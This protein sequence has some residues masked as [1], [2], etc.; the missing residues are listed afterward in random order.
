[1]NIKVGFVSLGC[2]KNLMN[3]ERMLALLA[4]EG[5]EIVAEDV[6]ADVM[7]INTCAFIESAKT[8]AIDSILDIAWLKEHHTLKG[9]VVAGCLP[10]R[11]GDEIL[12]EL[13][14]V[15]CIIG[16]GSVEKICEAVRA[17]YHGTSY[18]A[19]DDIH[20]APFGGERVVTTPEHF[21]YLQISE[22]C[23]NCCTYCVIP[24]IRGK[25]RSRPMSDLVEE[26]TELAEL[27]IKELCLIAQDTTRY[28]EDLYGTYA[29]DSLIA[30][31]SQIE[32]IEWIRLLYCYPDRITDGL[33]EEIANNPK[34]VKYIDMPIQ[35]INDDILK[36][37]NRRSNKAQ[38]MEVI[39]K[40]RSRVPG[41]ILRSTV[42]V[43]F[44]GETAAQFE[45]LRNFL[46]EI[47]FERLGVF[48][49]SR[50]E[51]TPAYDFP[52]QVSEKTKEK[53]NDILM[54]QQERIH[55]ECNE[56]F[57]GQTLKVICE[58]Y[59]QVSESFFGRSYADAYDI[60]GKIFF[61]ASKNVREGQFVNVLITEVM[62]YDLVGKV[63]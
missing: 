21:A 38:I 54:E 41:I 35:H 15:N 6:E 62:D 31:L 36:R 11:Y 2:P 39:Q 9:I 49:Y 33:I 55:N 44:P 57:L 17:A 14:E 19:F 23:D 40:L 12:K 46:K 50:E 63:V 27:G 3:T 20:T 22:G 18:R 30:E 53:R 42:I 13:P 29:L 24:S 10:Q 8:E 32:G 47:R 60:D 48:S 58:G 37:M 16:T 7:V 34:V 25:F 1:M 4:A 45:E 43:G 5:F 56:A 26:A 28:G 52:G 61:S 51:G 59:D